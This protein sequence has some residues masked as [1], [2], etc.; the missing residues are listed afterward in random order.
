MVLDA[1]GDA[2]T[3]LTNLIGSTSDGGPVSTAISVRHQPTEPAGSGVHTPDI[4]PVT[5]VQ[6][7]VDAIS[8]LAN[9]ATGTG[10]V[11][12]AARAIFL[13]GNTMAV[14]KN[15]DALAFFTGVV[16]GTSS[17]LDSDPATVQQCAPNKMIGACAVARSLAGIRDCL[18]SEF[19]FLQFD[20]SSIVFGKEVVVHVT[21]SGIEVTR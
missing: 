19:D 1:G 15:R 18:A 21:D 17:L 10:A 7:V 13:A 16:L 6:T 4:S 5:F 20:H 12:G 14:P 2:G 3:V 11:D 8:V 9:R